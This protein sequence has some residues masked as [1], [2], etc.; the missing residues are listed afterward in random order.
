M[1]KKIFI[2]LAIILCFIALIVYS[3]KDTTQ[4]AVSNSS[5][6]SQKNI[7]QQDNYYPFVLSIYDDKK[8]E[9]KQ[10]I[11]KEPQRIVVIGQGFAE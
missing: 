3:Q 5:S 8:N 6:V 4:N 7:S 1:V 9:I 10:I 2:L 11:E